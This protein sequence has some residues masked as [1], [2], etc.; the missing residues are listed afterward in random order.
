MSKFARFMARRRPIRTEENVNKRK[1][2]QFLLLSGLGREE[3][4]RGFVGGPQL[5][6]AKKK[7]AW[8]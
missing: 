4:E 7:I 1:M 5:T 6:F 2:T 8:L 3:G